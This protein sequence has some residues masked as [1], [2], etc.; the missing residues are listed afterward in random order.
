[1]WYVNQHI[2]SYGWRDLLAFSVIEDGTASVGARGHFEPAC[3]CYRA[4]IILGT[5]IIAVPTYVA[6]VSAMEGLGALQLWGTCL[7]S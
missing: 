3:Q 1:M 2:I 7:A 5:R 4:S 6:A